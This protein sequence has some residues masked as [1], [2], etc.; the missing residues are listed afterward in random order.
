MAHSRFNAET[1]KGK[2]FEEFPQALAVCARF[3]FIQH[4]HYMQTGDMSQGMAGRIIPNTK[5]RAP[6]FTSR[7]GADLSTRNGSLRD[8][9]PSRRR[10]WDAVCGG[11]FI[12]VV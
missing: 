6:R 10:H 9:S 12:R 7:F 11:R 1:N 2:R 3:F 4:T 5:L 8:V